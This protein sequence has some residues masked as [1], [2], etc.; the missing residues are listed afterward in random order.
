MPKEVPGTPPRA[1]VP[2]LLRVDPQSSPGRSDVVRDLTAGGLFIRTD[3]E[4]EPGTR[5]P[6]L[7]SA[8][9]LQ[10]PLQLEVEVAWRRSAEEGQQA[11]VAVKLPPDCPGDRRVLD[12]LA[13]AP[14]V[15]PDAKG[16]A[17]RIL[18]VEDNL[19]VGTMYE[20]AL[21]RLRTGDGAVEVALEYARDG[22]EALARLQRAP[23]L[24]LVVTDLYMPLMDGFSLVQ[25]IRDD[26][27]IASTPILAISAGSAEAR[28][29][30]VGSGADA[31][32]RKPIRTAELLREVRT[33]LKLPQ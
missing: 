10:E 8:P 17:Y 32:L 20:H 16:P 14:A 24:D 29:R 28:E 11:G 25:R 31:F 7:F 1:R 18:V 23:R 15:A 33:L 5:V 19:L 22:V 13:A 27:E 26:P 2:L 30:A 12:R 4:L 3:R 9:G 21:A 6:L